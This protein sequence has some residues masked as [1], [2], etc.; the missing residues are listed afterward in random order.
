LQSHHDTDCS[1]IVAL[2]LDNDPLNQQALQGR[3][4]DG[5]SLYDLAKQ[6]GNVNVSVVVYNRMG[7]LSSQQ[8]LKEMSVLTVI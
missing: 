3:R 7:K 6:N 4:A 2:L 5:C 8:Q 1:D